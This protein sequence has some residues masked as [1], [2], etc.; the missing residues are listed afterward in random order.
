MWTHGDPSQMRITQTGTKSQRNSENSSFYS[1]SN[2]LYS[3]NS[4][5]RVRVT[6]GEDPIEPSL[7]RRYAPCR[8]EFGLKRD[9][10]NFPN[11]APWDFDFSMGPH[12]RPMQSSAK[13]HDSSKLHAVKEIEKC[14]SKSSNWCTYF[15]FL[16]NSLSF[17]VF[18]SKS[19]FS[20][21]LKSETIWMIS[22][23][24]MI[25]CGLKVRIPIINRWKESLWVFFYKIKFKK[26]QFVMSF[27]I[28]KSK[29]FESF[30]FFID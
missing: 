30:K 16:F 8:W 21:E 24:N 25:F 19:F 3:F 2:I 23:G 10:C 11:W 15:C 22:E 26:S 27:P 13:D 5:G 28:F 6:K 4:H 29:V 17:L 9:I 18:W 14:S 1:R 7:T 20:V 12:G